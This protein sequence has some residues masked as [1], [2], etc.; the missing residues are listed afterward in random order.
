MRL[1]LRLRSGRRP[2]RATPVALPC[3]REHLDK[4]DATQPGT[5]RQKPVKR[6]QIQTSDEFV[7]PTAIIPARDALEFHGANSGAD[8][9]VEEPELVSDRGK[10][11]SEALPKTCP[12][13]RSRVEGKKKPKTGK[14]YWRTISSTLDTASY[15]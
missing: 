3:M 13:W 15:R 1:S 12:D 2:H 7:S 10:G 8:P 5:L 6:D 9:M 4:L 11:S 14:I